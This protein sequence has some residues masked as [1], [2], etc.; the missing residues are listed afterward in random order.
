M[1]L[2]LRA[3]LWLYAVLHRKCPEKH[4]WDTST[5]EV[6]FRIFLF[7]YPPP[8]VS[9]EHIMYC[10]DSTCPRQYFSEQYFL[11]QYFS[12]TLHF[13]DSTETNFSYFLYCHYYVLSRSNTDSWVVAGMSDCLTPPTSPHGK[14]YAGPILICLYTFYSAWLQWCS[15]TTLEW[16]LK[17]KA[18]SLNNS[19]RICQ[20]D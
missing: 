8:S 16:H 9:T 12:L 20:R 14:N 2:I 1:T 17:K 19:Y 13:C 6:L 15:C 11:W 4:F 5:L 18:N 3:L 7:Y 10:H